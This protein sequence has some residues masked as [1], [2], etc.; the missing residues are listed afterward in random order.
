MNVTIEKLK[1]LEDFFNSHSIPK[2]IM[3]FGAI[4][5]YDVPRFV[6]DNLAMLKSGELIGLSA[7]VRFND[8]LDLKKAIEEKDAGGLT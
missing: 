1:E 7:T 2:E 5:Y 8:L 6:W 4:T 3:L